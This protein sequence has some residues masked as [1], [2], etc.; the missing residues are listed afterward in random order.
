MLCPE[1]STRN[2][3]MVVS[4]RMLSFCYHDKCLIW[5][6]T[7]NSSMVGIFRRAPVTLQITMNALFDVAFLP[8]LFFYLEAPHE[9]TVC[10]TRDSEYRTP[11]VCLH[12]AYDACWVLE[13]PDLMMFCYLF[14]ASTANN[15][16]SFT[17]AYY[18]L[19]KLTQN[20]N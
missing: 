1:C 3:V 11:D 15:F 20:L 6:S 13:L 19:S 16:Y 7:R 12:R 10:S 17:L 8:L 14:A 9:E 4:G 2:S 18:I 5:Y